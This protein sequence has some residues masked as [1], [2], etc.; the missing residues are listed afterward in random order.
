MRD[1]LVGLPRPFSWLLR[2]K[3]YAEKVHTLPE[4]ATMHPSVFRRLPLAN[5][6][7]AGSS[8][9][10]RPDAL[11]PVKAAAEFFEKAGKLP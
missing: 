8:E 2:N 11:R 6:Q 3:N 7:H 1:T 10:Y 4:D 9:P 5:V